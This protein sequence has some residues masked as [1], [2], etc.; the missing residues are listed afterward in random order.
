MSECN[1]L[2]M[3]GLSVREVKDVSREPEPRRYHLSSPCA[4][5]V[6]HVAPGIK[7]RGW[8]CLERGGGGRGAGMCRCYRDD[9]HPIRT[10]PPCGSSLGERAGH[11]WPP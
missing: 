11:S 10:Q 9:L 4:R 7:T 1:S 6:L 5:G 3:A 2:K 8:W